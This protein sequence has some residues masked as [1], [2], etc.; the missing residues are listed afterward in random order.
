VA[1]ELER[2]VFTNN[3]IFRPVILVN[4]KWVGTWSRIE[5]KE[6]VLIERQLVQPV[7]IA[8]EKAIV[9]AC[10]KYGRFLGKPL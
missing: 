6:H 8:S 4:G 10:K 2:H 3:G 1:R 7:S 9:T 5:K